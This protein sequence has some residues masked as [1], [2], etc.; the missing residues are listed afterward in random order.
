MIHDGGSRNVKEGREGSQHI[1]EGQNYEGRHAENSPQEQNKCTN[2]RES[3]KQRG[4][5]RQSRIVES[6]ENEGDKANCGVSV[7]LG[8]FLCCCVFCSGPSV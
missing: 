5:T 6:E 7:V 4:Q 1:G 8:V 3:D 2:R